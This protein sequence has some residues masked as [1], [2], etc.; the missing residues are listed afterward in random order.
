M[1]LIGSNSDIFVDNGDG[2]F[3]H[4]TV[5]GQTL[6]FDANT[7]T[8]V[9]NGDGT[10]VFTNANGDT[11]TVDVIGDVVTNIQNY[12]PTHSSTVL[13]IGSNSDIFVDNGD[14]TFTHTT[15][16]GQTVTFDA[17]TTTMV[18][19]GD[20]T[21]V[22]TNANG[23]T[24]TVDVIGDVVTNIQNQ[25]DIYTEIMNLI[26]SNSDIFVDNGD[27]TFTHTTVDGTVLTFDANTTTMVDN[28]DGTYVFTN[29]NGDTIT[30]DV[31]GDVVTNIQNYVPTHSSTVLLIGSNS[32]IFVDNG[33]GTF[34]HTTVDG[35]TLIFDA[36]TTTMVDNGDGTYVFTNANG[37]TITVDVIGDVVTNIQNQG[38][39]YTEI[40]NLIGSNSDIFVD[41]GDG[42]FTHT[43]VDGQTV[44]F[45]ANTTTMVDNGDGTY[46]FT[47]ANGDTITVDVIG[48]VVTN[49]Q[50][51][52]DIYN[53][54][55]NLIG[56]NS[57]IF[58]DNGDGTFTHTTVDGQTVTFDANTTTM[59]NNGEVGRA[60]RSAN[61]E[62]ITVDVI[63]D[64]ITNIQNQ[65][66]IYTE[67]MNLIGSNS[68]IMVDNGDGTYVFTNAN[69]DTITVDV[70]GDVV[71]NIQNQGDIY[72]EIMNLIGSNSDIFVDNGDGTFTHTTVDGQTLIFDANTT[73]MVNNGDGTYVFTNANGDT[74]TVDVIGDVVTNIQNQGDIYN[75][76][77]NL[78]GSNS[79]IFVDNG[80]GTFTHTTVDGQTVTFDANT[81]TMVNNGDGTY[82]FTNANGDTITV[83]VIGDV[84]TNIQ[85]QGDIYN[86]I[87][88]LIGSNSDIFVDNGDGTFTHTT[89]DGT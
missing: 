54:I 86:E 33:D 62:T 21:Y 19:N 67:I 56:S 77:M 47:N 7:T 34:T 80:D 36:N 55:M 4:A 2:T 43:T 40:M 17:N 65:G 20:G 78:I 83:D 72:N 61:G 46:V 81:T 82:V 25:G 52:G 70:I 87:M 35:Q 18:N 12:V 76:I 38:D 68:D 39:I 31:I 53:E 10:Y 60:S 79:D 45:D 27:G 88:N 23:D 63:G 49:I 69:G 74:I 9:D 13:L 50:N 59:V 3:T 41:N 37:D 85:N 1:I 71:T 48:D 51:Q 6:I 89:V 57:D 66:V 84:V 44:T 16:D 30:V 32:D 73:T 58:V 8:M 15:V 24:I 22:F 5:D 42:T 64:V 29:A 75:E 11:I 28:G 26:G 14:G